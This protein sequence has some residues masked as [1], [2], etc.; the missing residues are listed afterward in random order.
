MFIFY[1]GINAPLTPLTPLTRVKGR[2]I[3]YHSTQTK[4]LTKRSPKLYMNHKSFYLLLKSQV[5]RK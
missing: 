5:L 2:T 4:K 3:F 1:I